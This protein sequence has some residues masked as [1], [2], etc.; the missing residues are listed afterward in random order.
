MAIGHDEALPPATREIDATGKYVLPGLIDCHV[1]I[2][3]VYDDWRTGPL[4]AAHA[5]LTTL[6]SFVGYDDQTARP[7]PTRSSGCPTRRGR[8]PWSIS[9]STSSSTT[10]RTSST[11][12]AEAV[13][14]GVSTSSSS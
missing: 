4:G 8:S 3:P 9:A 5:G 12:L 14:M 10:S 11:G 7:C 1:H 6:L 13:E 2:G